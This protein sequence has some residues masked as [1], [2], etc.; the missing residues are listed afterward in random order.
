MSATTVPPAQSSNDHQTARIAGREALGWELGSLAVTVVL[1][2]LLTSIKSSGAGVLAGY[3]LGL[4]IYVAGL[5]FIEIVAIRAVRKVVP[6]WNQQRRQVIPEPPQT[7]WPALGPVVTA[8]AAAIIIGAAAYLCYF[9]DHQVSLP[10]VIES[11]NYSVQTVTTVGYGDWIPKSMPHTDPRLLAMRTF[12][13]FLML[14]GA[15]FFGIFIGVLT[16]W[17]QDL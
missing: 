12:S 16:T 2:F 11:L 1:G 15:A 5:I 9:Y 13:I 7:P 17:Y 8:L 10:S 3:V 14:S 4:L 6:L